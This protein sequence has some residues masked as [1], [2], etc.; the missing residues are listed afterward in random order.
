MYREYNMNKSLLQ[1]INDISLIKLYML[2]NKK[3]NTSTAICDNQ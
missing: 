1:I 2:M 3:I